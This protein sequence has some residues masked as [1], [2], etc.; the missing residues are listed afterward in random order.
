MNDVILYGA[1]GEEVELGMKRRRTLATL[2]LAL[3]MCSSL[4]ILGFSAGK[5]EH[6]TEPTW[7]TLPSQTMT[8]TAVFSGEAATWNPPEVPPPGKDAPPLVIIAGANTYHIHYTTLDWLQR[9]GCNA[10]TLRDEHE[11][12]LARTTD[13]AE[14]R[15]VLL[16]ELIHASYKETGDDATVVGMT[17]ENDFVGPIAPRLLQIL[18]DNPKLSSWLQG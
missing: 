5:S 4:L 3:A 12:W 16:H 9:R 10:F 18:R 6:R 2:I 1:D 15:I 8:F 17:N 11:I 7:Q 13:A 14:Q